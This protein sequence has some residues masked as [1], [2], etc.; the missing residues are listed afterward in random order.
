MTDNKTG[1]VC[2]CGITVQARNLSE[3]QTSARHIQKMVEARAHTPGVRP[4]ERRWSVVSKY[5]HQ[6][7]APQRYKKKQ[8]LLALQLAVRKAQAELEVCTVNA[9]EDGYFTTTELADLLAI[10][11]TTV[12]AW[13]K[14]IDQ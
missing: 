12:F 1:T 6:L 7:T 14:K 11:R 5:N 13:R 3:H 4:G 9:Y 2:A 10:S 8:E